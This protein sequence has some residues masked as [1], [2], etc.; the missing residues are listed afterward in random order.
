MPLSDPIHTNFSS[1]EI[2]QEAMARVDVQRQANGCELVRNMFIHQLGPAIRRGG[3][4]YVGETKDSSKT[5]RLIPFEFNVSQAYIMEFG[6]AYVRFY[7]EEGQLES[8]PGTPYEIVAPWAHTDL[9]YIQWAQ[10][11][12]VMYIVHP[13]YSIRKLV[14]SGHTSW[15]LS[16][17]EIINGPFLDLN[18]TAVTITPSGTTGTVTLTASAATFVSDHVGAYWYLKHGA[19]AGYVEITA[20]T[21]TT[22]VTATVKS[23]LGG[24]GATTEWAEG[25]WSD[26]QGYPQAVTI[27]QERLWLGGTDGSPQTIWGSVNGDYEDHAAGAADIDAV[28]YTLGSERVNAIQWMTSRDQTLMVGTAGGEIA[29]T[30]STTSPAL[31]P[32]SVNAAR[33]SKWGGYN[34]TPVVVNNEVLFLTRSQRKIRAIKFNIDSDAEIAQD[35]NF[36]SYEITGGKIYEMA[37]SSEPNQI[38]WAVRGD[39]VLLG[40]TFVREED[41]IAWHK[42][43]TGAAGEFESVATIPYGEQSQLWAAIKRTINGDTVRYIEF[44]DPDYFVDSLL[45]YSGPATDTFAGL[46]HLEGETLKVLADGAVQ[47]DVT[48]SSGLVTIQNEAEEVVIGVGYESELKPVRLEGTNPAGTS[49][50][51][52]R[53]WAELFVRLAESQKPLVNGRRPPTF[54][55]QSTMD[56]APPLVTEDVRITQ[57][58]WSRD[59]FVHIT[60]DDPLP[61]KVLGIFGTMETS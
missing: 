33:K 53:K 56:E 3:F 44:L 2:S 22:H 35:L 38:L 12:D 15:A 16:E 49:Q 37:F 50:G 4:H 61:L 54:S 19:S 25:A 20:Y 9:D 18:T 51:R 48:V 28:I 59:G 7:T 32:S 24:T 30:G 60:A 26:V 11:G 8:A 36:L 39:G 42:H 13:D 41:V 52:L 43:D 27:F 17:P 58:G 5:V 23:T 46:D 1:G 40:M 34:I 6:D 21:D 47:P 57:L 45:T 14:R 31:T 10:T 55:G 29:L